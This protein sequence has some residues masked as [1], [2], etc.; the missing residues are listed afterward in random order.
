MSLVAPDTVPASMAGES[1]TK[2]TSH[3][4][5]NVGVPHAVLH[6]GFPLGRTTIRLLRIVMQSV[7][8]PLAHFA[9]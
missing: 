2:L 7:N 4:S 3:L 8:S 5:P 6:D 1:G 9:I